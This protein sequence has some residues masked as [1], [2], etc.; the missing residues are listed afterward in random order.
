MGDFEFSPVYQEHCEQMRSGVSGN[1]LQE[2]IE[3]DHAPCY[4]NGICLK[5]PVSQC[6]YA[7]AEKDLQAAI[8][9][10]NLAAAERDRILKQL[11]VCMTTLNA[12]HEWMKKCQER[13]AVVKA[14]ND[15]KKLEN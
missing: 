11:M 9:A 10:Y 8:S 6:L 5:Y 4:V 7:T 12:D 15:V 1:V 2:Y 14:V 13:V 3:K